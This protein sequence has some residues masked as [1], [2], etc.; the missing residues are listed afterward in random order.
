MF[1]QLSFTAELHLQSFTDDNSFMSASGHLG[2]LGSAS[3][4]I[5]GL[6]Q[7]IEEICLPVGEPSAA[8]VLMVESC[9]AKRRERRF[10]SHV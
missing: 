1:S 6:F 9:C 7:L 4:L 3:T 2:H 5:P 8:L 10:L